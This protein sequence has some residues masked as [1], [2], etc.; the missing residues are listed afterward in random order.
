MSS[1]QYAE[2]HNL[3]RR[4][5]V[6]RNTIPDGELV[7]LIRLADEAGDFWTR[8][9]VTRILSV[10]REFQEEW[11]QAP[12][13]WAMAAARNRSPWTAEM[14]KYL[15]KGWP[16]LMVKTDFM[17]ILAT[18]PA[19][20]AEALLKLYENQQIL[21]VEIPDL[22]LDTLIQMAPGAGGNAPAL[23]ARVI[24][25]LR[26]HDHSWGERV[27]S[28][29]YHEQL[30]DAQPEIVEALMDGWPAI[31]PTLEPAAAMKPNA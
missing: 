7:R 28:W 3:L 25:L 4:Y 15:I 27:A 31:F 18:H 29:L 8:T 2:L 14:L 12:L 9:R 30:K 1:K 20:V 6:P 26:P 23:T 17:N 10:A 21:P 13:R 19:A 24:S 22:V 5:R 16:F 11:A